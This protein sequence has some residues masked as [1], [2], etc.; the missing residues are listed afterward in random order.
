MKLIVHYNKYSGE[1]DMN[2]LVKERFTNK[3]RFITVTILQ[4]SNLYRK[5][6]NMEYFW[7]KI[8]L[9]FKYYNDNL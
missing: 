5:L 1:S 3:L 6:G 2:I 7:R 9:D 4:S 8:Y